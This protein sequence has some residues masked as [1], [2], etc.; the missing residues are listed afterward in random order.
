MLKVIFLLEEP[1]MQILLEGILPR[2]FP[3]LN[4][5]CLAYSGKYD[6]DRN[7]VNVLRTWREPDTR[8]V[9]VRDNDNGDCLALKDRLH[10]LCQQG[11]RNDTLI[12]IVCQELEAWYLGEPNAM[13]DAFGNE[14]LR[15]IGNRAKYRNPDT[16]QN[17]SNDIKSLAPGF[18][19]VGAARR[20]AEHLTREG[21]RSRS[22]A[23]FLDGVAALAG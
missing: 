14:S 2:L 23:V 10:G 4:F 11:G 15:R 6:L 9:I 7:I 21:N 1:S 13:A 17:P 5:Q 18:G 19:K 16:L 3:S 20:M 12:R 22:F 8:F